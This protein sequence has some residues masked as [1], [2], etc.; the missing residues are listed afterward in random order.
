MCLLYAFR[1]QAFVGDLQRSHDGGFV[2]LHHLP[3]QAAEQRAL[4]H[5]E[6][7]FEQNGMS[8]SD[9]DLPQLDP[10]LLEQHHPDYDSS[11]RIASTNPN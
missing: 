9:F 4:Q 6:S 8:C 10:A 2:D 1:R 7:I 3:L 5:I 11:G